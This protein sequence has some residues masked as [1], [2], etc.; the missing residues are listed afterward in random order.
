MNGDT[1]LTL[2]KLKRYVE[3]NTKIDLLFINQLRETAAEFF[4]QAPGPI[5]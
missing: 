2:N 5:D 4:A 3:F 1:A